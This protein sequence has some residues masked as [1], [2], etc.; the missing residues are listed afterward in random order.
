MMGWLDVLMCLLEVV[1]SMLECVV[2]LTKSDGAISGCPFKKGKLFVL[3]I[4]SATQGRRNRDLVFLSKSWSR[5][6]ADTLVP[7]LLEGVWH[8]V[9]SNH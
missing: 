2:R 1:S 9:Q 5:C 4:G 6:P 7:A 8:R 3:S